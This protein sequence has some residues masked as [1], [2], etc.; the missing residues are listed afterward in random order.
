MVSLLELEAY[1]GKTRVF[2]VVKLRRVFLVVKLPQSFA[3]DLWTPDSHRRRL[4][5]R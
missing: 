4:A 2:L 3:L 1:R 5:M